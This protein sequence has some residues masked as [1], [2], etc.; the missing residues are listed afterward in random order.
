MRNDIDNHDDISVHIY[1]WL[2]PSTFCWLV[3]CYKLFTDIHNQNE[4]G[5]ISDY[6]R[7]NGDVQTFSGSGEPST[8][9]NDYA[10]W[11][12]LF[13]CLPL[14]HNYGVTVEAPEYQGFF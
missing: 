1:F 8:S 11:Y 9:V 6:L 7:Q 4:Y 13:I 2:Q 12:G 5:F 3:N 14:I 10:D